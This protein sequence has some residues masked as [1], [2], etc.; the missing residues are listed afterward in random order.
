MHDLVDVAAMDPEH[1]EIAQHCG[2]AAWRK[3][4]GKSSGEGVF[5]KVGAAEKV[6]RACLAPAPEGRPSATDLAALLTAS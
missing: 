5:R 4:L 6:I 1:G 2:T 3:R